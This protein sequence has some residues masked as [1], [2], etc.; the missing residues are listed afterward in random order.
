MFGCSQ[1]PSIFYQIYRN[2]K[3]IYHGN[4]GCD[5]RYMSQVTIIFPQA[6]RAWYPRIAER[7]VV[8]YHER[9]AECSLGTLRVLT[10]RPQSAHLSSAERELGTRVRTYAR[11][12]LLGS[13]GKVN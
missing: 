13:P 2:W 5:L 4:P 1:T 11:S 7:Q 12:T 10:L 6:R 8:G 9:P 3:S